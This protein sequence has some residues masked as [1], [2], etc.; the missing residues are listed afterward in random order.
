MICLCFIVSAFPIFSPLTEG[1]RTFCCRFEIYDKKRPSSQ[2]GLSCR[3]DL[4]GRIAICFLFAISRFSYTVGSFLIVLV[5]KCSHYFF[6]FPLKNREGFGKGREPLPEL[7]GGFGGPRQ[8]VPYIFPML[9]CFWGPGHRGSWGSGAGGGRAGDAARHCI[10]KG[11][12][13]YILTP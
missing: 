13:Y 7:Q 9:T 5:S 6:T 8:K 10:V 3:G 2:I 1:F 12:I 11:I 4:K